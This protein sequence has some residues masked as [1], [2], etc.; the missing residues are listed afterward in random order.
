MNLIA[1]LNK[2]INNKLYIQLPCV[3][4]SVADSTFFHVIQFHSSFFFFFLSEESGTPHTNRLDE[5]PFYPERFPESLPSR[6][7]QPPV[8]EF[9]DSHS[10]APPLHMDQE[11]RMPRGPRYSNNLDK[12]TSA[13]LELVARK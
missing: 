8:G 1:S 3:R 2:I 10:S 4:G 11:S 9:F 6:D 5:P 12:I 13:L 7:Y